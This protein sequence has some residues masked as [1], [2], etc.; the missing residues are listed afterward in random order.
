MSKTTMTP[1]VFKQKAIDSLQ[2]FDPGLILRG[3]QLTVVGAY[4]ALQNPHLF[5][6]SHYKKAALAV[7]AG[8]L[9]RIIVDLPIFGVKILLTFSGLFVDLKTQSW[10]DWI[11]KGLQFLE[12]NVLQIPFF[13]MTLTI[14]LQ[15]DALDEMFMESLS[16]VDQTYLQKH[17]NDNPSTLRPPYHQN[18]I[19]Y[20]KNG[21]ASSS[22]SST[23]SSS[24]SSPPQS[25]SSKLA[26]TIAQKQTDF[27]KQMLKKGL[28]SLI[29]YISSLIPWAGILV[30]P[31]ASAWSLHP[32]VGIGPAL[33]VFLTGLFVP[34]KQMVIVLQAYHA[35]RSLVRTLLEPYFSRIPFTPAQK[36]KWYRERQGLLLG[37]GIGFYAF[38]RI[39]LLGVLIYGI[40]EASTAYLITKITDPPPSKPSRE[41]LEEYAADQAE[42]RNKQEFVALPLRDLEEKVG[43]VISEVK[44]TKKRKN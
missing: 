18:L 23:R 17:Q 19:L 31:A 9:L 35:S 41:A 40:A 37:F 39:P 3:A 12:K 6:S 2:S 5:R 8:L 22:S 21:P 7:A 24:S 38:L 11:I 25:K 16:W 13:L 36:K 15:R 4:R 43:R 14:R 1:E 34:R 30:L 44:E 33:G 42:W 32:T 29:V 27:I 26:A 28:I 10:D 20:P